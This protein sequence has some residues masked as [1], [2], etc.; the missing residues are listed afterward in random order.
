MTFREL[1]LLVSQG[2][3]LHVEFKHKLPEWPKLMR[4]VVAFANTH[5]GTIWIGVDDDG[6]ISGLRDP[7][8]IEE[9]IALNLNEWV[10]PVPDW[11]LVVVPLSRKRAVVGIVVNRSLTKPHFAKESLIDEVGHALIR[12]AD[13]SVRASKEAVELLR[14]EGRERDMKVEYGDK[15][16][17]LMQHIAVS[18]HITVQ[19]F[20]DLAQIAR[21]SASRTLVHLVKSNVLYHRPL[22]DEE[23]RFYVKGKL[24]E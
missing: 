8:E 9:A 20:A 12:I 22:I 5:G 15:E 7:R 21:S 16:R 18:K 11:R 17:I 6:T 14:Y 23:D 24:G 1:Q 19:E 10:R 2:E 13:S 3:N 4:E